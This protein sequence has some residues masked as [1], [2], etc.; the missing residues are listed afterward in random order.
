VCHLH[1]A[2]QVSQSQARQEVGGVFLR[3][4]DIWVPL[5]HLGA[6]PFI[7]NIKYARMRYFKKQNSKIFTRLAPQECF[8]LGPAVALDVPGES[9]RVL[10]YVSVVSERLAE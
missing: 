7:R 8:F 1:S 6:Q 9:P 4:R 5:Q 2:H 3:P 10:I